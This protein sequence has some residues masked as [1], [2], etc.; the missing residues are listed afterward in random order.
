MKHLSVLFLFTIITGGFARAQNDSIIV[1]NK[2]CSRPDTPVLFPTANNVIRIYSKGVKPGELT[3]KSL[4]NALKIGSPEIKGDT[5]SIMAMPYP[6][7]GAKMRLAIMNKKNQKILKTINFYCEE[8]PRPVAT[9][10]NITKTDVPRKDVLTQTFLKVSFGQ[11]LYNYPY[12]VK[13]YS[14]KTRIAGKDILITGNGPYLTKDIQDKMALAPIGTLIEFVDIK[15]TCPE[16]NER[17][18]PNLR[19]WVR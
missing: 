3:V 4:D 19:V 11:S 8:P 1:W 10:G 7:A 12:Y 6:K 2:W 9:L 18:L 13:K 17:T 5:I 16:C 14:F 15:A